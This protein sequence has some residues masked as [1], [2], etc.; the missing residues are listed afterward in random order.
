MSQIRSVLQIRSEQIG[1]PFRCVLRPELP[2]M[3][4]PF[5][6]VLCRGCKPETS[7]GE[8]VPFPSSQPLLCISL[9]A[10]LLLPLSLPCDNQRSPTEVSEA[11]SAIIK[12]LLSNTKENFTTRLQNTTCPELR[13]KPQNCTGSPNQDF[14]ST[15]HALSCDMRHLNLSETAQLAKYVLQ[16]IQCPCHQTQNLTKVSNMVSKENAKEGRKKQKKHKGKR[17]KLCRAKVILSS[18]TKCYEMLNSI[19][20][21]TGSTVRSAPLP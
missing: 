11:Y 2:G 15:L 8:E 19:L 10:L 16:S 1:A 20:E 14:V 18:M 9:L 12:T 4:R 17:R 3:E 5:A 6:S 21:A 7:G 13:Q